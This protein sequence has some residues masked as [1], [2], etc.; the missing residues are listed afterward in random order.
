MSNQTHKNKKRFG[1]NFLID[2]KII[3][4][5]INS[6]AAKKTDNMVEIGVG[7]GALTNPLLQKL[8]KLNII[9]IDNDLV[10]FWQQKNIANLSINAVDV[11]KFDFTTL[12]TDIRVV[13]NLPYNISS[14]I[15]FQMIDIK[16]NIKD[17]LFMLQQEVVERIVAKEGSKIYGRLSVMIQAFFSAEMLFIVPNTAFDPPP[18]VSSAIIY[19]SPIKS[20]VKNIDDFAK[21]VKASFSMRRKTLNNCLKKLLNASQTTIDLSR[22]AESLSVDEFILLSE[23]YSKVCKLMQ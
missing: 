19:L 5:I 9:E 12:G 16:D 17:M 21:I 23:D 20:K 14:P 10:D 3:D 18:K 7:L 4:N 8:D 2:E 22:R 13:G 6:I 1:Q 15:L 11:L